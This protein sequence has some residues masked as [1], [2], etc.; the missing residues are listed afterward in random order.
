MDENERLLALQVSSFVK[1]FRALLLALC[2]YELQTRM[3][4]F[5]WH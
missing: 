4:M 5:I 1:C 2:S 3:P